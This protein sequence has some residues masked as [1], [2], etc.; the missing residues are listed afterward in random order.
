MAFK[1]PWLLLGASRVLA[2]GLHERSFGW[3]STWFSMDEKCTGNL[4]WQVWIMLTGIVVNSFGTTLED[5]PDKI[6]DGNFGFHWGLVTS[7]RLWTLVHGLLYG[8]IQK[9]SNHD[10][11]KTMGQCFGCKLALS[12]CD[13]FISTTKVGSGVSS[14]NNK[15]SL[16]YIPSAPKWL[17][18]RD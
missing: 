18:M 14:S 13:G 11:L 4:T 5:K 8:L 2:L 3:Q 9:V 7:K 15:V 6:Y 17:S 12:S 1:N 10:H 16:W